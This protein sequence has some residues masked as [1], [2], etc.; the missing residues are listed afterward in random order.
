[1]F[2]GGMV[3]GGMVQVGMVQGGMVQE[4]MVQG[5]MVQAG[6]RTSPLDSWPAELGTWL[7]ASNVHPSYAMVPL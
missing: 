1:M 7:Q 2:Q 6:A 3:Q 5:G 4:G